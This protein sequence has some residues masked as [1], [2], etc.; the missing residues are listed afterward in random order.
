M[1][2]LATVHQL[3]KKLEKNQVLTDVSCTFEK[4]MIY[5]L[6]GRNG[7]GKT[8]LLNLIAGKS[9]PDS[10]SIEVNGHKPF[11]HFDTLNQICFIRESKNFK[12]TLTIKD[13]LK[14]MPAFYPNWSSEKALELLELFELPHH[15]KVAQLSKGMES[16]LGITVGI[17]SRAPLTIF[18]EPYIGMDAHA[19]E[20]FYNALLEDYTEHPRTIILST[21]L[22]DEVSDLFQEIYFMK[23]GQI[24]MHET[25]NNLQERAF[26]ITGPKD[27]IESLSSQGRVL[28]RSSFMG[29]HSVTLYVD[30][31]QLQTFH[32]QQIAQ[33]RKS[34]YN[35]SWFT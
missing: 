6:L 30:E 15:K 19:R 16:A 7:A 22:I 18:D 21:H 26:M 8:T 9:L 32:I 17:S 23:K 31:D 13:I 24:S 33:D 11:N 35:S 27:T 28:D 14:M 10:G 5:G 2:N 3:S 34:R 20:E 25:I 4:D 12:P 29:D 1:T